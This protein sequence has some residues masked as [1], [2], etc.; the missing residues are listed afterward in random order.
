MNTRSLNILAL[1]LL[2]PVAAA[3]SG[4]SSAENGGAGPQDAGIETAA[5]A[6]APDAADDTVGQDAVVAEAAVEASSEASIAQDAAKDCVAAF[7]AEIAPVIEDLLYMSESDYPFEVFSHPDDGTGEIS[8]SHMLG[9]LGLPADTAVEQRTPDQFFTE[10]LMTGPD[11][12]KY[13]QM[14]SIL[15]ANMS[16]L[17]VI[18]IG[19]I[20]IDV[21]VV[22][23]TECGEIAGLKTTAIET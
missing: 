13:Q 2:L 14:K 11:G 22:G 5:E 16:G 4:E 17:T 3:C 18:R 9:V 21:F 10:Y 6:S 7:T 20:E 19:T 23:R 1:S 12:A 15:E 8:A